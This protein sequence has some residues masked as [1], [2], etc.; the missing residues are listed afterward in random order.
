[1]A[2]GGGDAGAA[3]EPI[4]GAGGD[5]GDGPVCG[6]GLVTGDEAVSGACDDGNLQ[7]GDGCSEG[8]A[9]EPGWTCDA[10]ASTKCTSICGDGRVVGQEAL[11]G[12]CDDGANA[13]GDGCDDECKVEPG[14]VCQDQPSACAKTCGNGKL[15][16]GETCEDGNQATKDGCVSCTVE[17]GYTCDNAALPSKCIDV[18]ECKPGGD[19]NCSAN[20]TCANTVGSFTCKCKAGFTGDGVT[21]ANVDECADNKDN[22]HADA[23]CTDTAGSFTC[24]CKTGYSGNG[25]TSCARISCFGLTDGCGNQGN[26]DCCSAPV[27]PGYEE[28][29]AYAL[30]KYEV[31]VGRFKKFVDAYNGHPANGVGADPTIANSG[32]RS[33]AWDDE[34]AANKAALINAVQCNATYQTWSTSAE[35]DFKPINCVSWYEAFAFCAW[36]GGWLPDHGEWKLAASG[37]NLWTYPWGD[38]PAP[39]DKVDASAAYANYNCM[40]DGGIPGSCSFADIL[41]VGSKPLGAGKY[42]H[43]DLAGSVFEWNIDICEGDCGDLDIRGIP[44]GAWNSASDRLMSGINVG[45]LEPFKHSASVGFR[46]ARAP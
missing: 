5:A 26:D 23:V 9:V 12:G 4:A 16:A 45:G 37:G 41:R 30:D 3:A 21:C 42:G 27:A 25:T 2:G 20:A 18:N 11:A 38:T 33:P 8:C 43:L 32:W 35:N 36:D 31:T 40:G 17:K 10:N 1:M 19:N 44:G 29:P 34:I 46:C 39:T 7:P 24:K 15:D 13:T 14:Y 28:L 22:C 6:D